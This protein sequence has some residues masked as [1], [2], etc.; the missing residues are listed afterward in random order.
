MGYYRRRKF[1]WAVTF[2]VITMILVSF[3]AFQTYTPPSIVLEQ[4]QNNTPAITWN[5]GT[6]TEEGGGLGTGW[7]YNLKA[8]L[9][10]Y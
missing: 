4:W 3:I 1:S 5:D 7:I 10:Y 9:N 2:S 6:D 8:R